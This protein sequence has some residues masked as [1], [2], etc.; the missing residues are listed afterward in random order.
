[1]T[2]RYD[3]AVTEPTVAGRG[4]P[5]DQHRL[6]QQGQGTRACAPFSMAALSGASF[7]WAGSLV[8]V[9]R[10]RLCAAAHPH[11]GLSWFDS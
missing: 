5:K 11:G 7:G 6:S 10:P 2:L 4:N 9:F 8:P 1:M 3:S